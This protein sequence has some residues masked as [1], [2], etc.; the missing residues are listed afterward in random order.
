MRT[1]FLYWPSVP[2]SVL[3]VQ[4]SKQITVN[5]LESNCLGDKLSF[6]LVKNRDTRVRTMRGPVRR[7]K[8]SKF[9]LMKNFLELIILIV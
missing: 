8:I 5:S 3:C 4:F 2:L 6:D 9:D 1:W 7:Q